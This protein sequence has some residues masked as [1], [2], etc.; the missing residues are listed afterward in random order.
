MK[1]RPNSQAFYPIFEHFKAE[2]T[3]YITL[4][5]NKLCLKFVKK[6]ETKARLSE[7]R[8]CPETLV[9]TGVTGNPAVC[10]NSR[11][12]AKWR[13]KMRYDGPTL[14]ETEIFC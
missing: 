5:I 3:F 14:H 4:K 7:M 6:Q 1:K 10:V 13:H 8:R 2:F 9:Y 11:N 12:A